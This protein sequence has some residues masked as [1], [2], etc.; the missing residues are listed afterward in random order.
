MAARGGP[1]P[2][3]SSGG[4]RIDPTRGV[5]GGRSHQGRLKHK[6]RSIR[7]LMLMAALARALAR[8][9]MSTMASQQGMT[10]MMMQADM[11]DARGMRV[12]VG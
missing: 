4:R 12:C 10:L 5:A 2:G 7:P 6:A 8:G 1:S 11:A 9:A 3:D